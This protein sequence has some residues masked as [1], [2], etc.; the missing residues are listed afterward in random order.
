MSNHVGGRD[1]FYNHY[2]FTGWQHWGQVMGNPLYLSPIYNENGDIYVHNNRFMAFHL[3]FDG[4]PT[5][6]LHY[7]SLVTWQDGLGTYSDP[8][9]K[10]RH[11]LS[12]LF[13]TDYRFPYGWKV[14]GAWGMDAGNIRGNNQGFQLTVSKIFTH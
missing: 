12:I 3:G 6:R 2:I 14:K 1:D 8:Y 7:R 10:K 5:E 13:E 11:S 9:T 4:N